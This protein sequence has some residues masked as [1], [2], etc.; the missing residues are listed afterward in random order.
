MLAIRFAPDECS[1]HGSHPEGYSPRCSH[2][3]SARHTVHTPKG[4]CRAVRTR[5]ML[6]ARSTP[7]RA[8]AE[9]FAPQPEC[10]PPGPHPEGRSPNGSHPEGRSPVG[11]HPGMLAARSTPRRAFAER[12]APRRMLAR[13]RFARG[14]EAS[15]AVRRSQ[16]A[17][18]TGVATS[19]S[20]A[21][22]RQKLPYEKALGWIAPSA[23]P[24]PSRKDG[25]QTV[26]AVGA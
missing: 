24:E 15:R 7:R 21:T 17:R 13:R 11:S 23:A 4:A 10:S 18:T 14:R 19:G 1:R 8:F 3:M 16:T 2:P 12:F 22:N 5:G 6:P 26:S 25:I 20:L 9:R